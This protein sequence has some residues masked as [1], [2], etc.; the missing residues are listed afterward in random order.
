MRAF[1]NRGWPAN[2]PV[3]D[4]LLRLRWDIA[5]RLGY[6]NWAE[7]NIA[8]HMVPTSDS[9]SAFIESIRARS[10]SAVNTT[11]ARYLVALQ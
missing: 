11:L 6:R 8:Q 9:A 10:A 3:L 4:S 7:D 2:V 1:A 5:H